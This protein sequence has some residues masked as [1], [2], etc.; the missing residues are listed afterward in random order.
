MIIDTTIRTPNDMFLAVSC[1]LEGAARDTYLA[2]MENRTGG[3]R[4]MMAHS[5]DVAR[6]QFGSLRG[7]RGYDRNARI[8]EIV[9]FAFNF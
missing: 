1:L 8:R 6:E 9:D 4:G 3:L 2:R 5:V 7:M